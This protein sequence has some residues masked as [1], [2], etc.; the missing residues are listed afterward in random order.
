[1]RTGPEPLNERLSLRRAEYI[2]ERLEAD[3]PPLRN[4]T[5]TSG[6][7]SRENLVGSA[8]DDARD[9]LDRRVEFKV[10]GCQRQVVMSRLVG[11]PVV[12]HASVWRGSRASG[13]C[14]AT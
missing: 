13:F 8:T 5:I 7:G 3:A 12:S 4:R 11:C 9:A 1:S 2:Q 10:I 6:K 14:S